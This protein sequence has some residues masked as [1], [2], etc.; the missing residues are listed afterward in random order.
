MKK[1]NPS[2]YSSLR[3]YQENYEFY[4][5]QKEIPE[6]LSLK[7]LQSLWDTDVEDQAKAI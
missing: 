7:T 1:L 4:R 2:I 5:T 6:L 3:K